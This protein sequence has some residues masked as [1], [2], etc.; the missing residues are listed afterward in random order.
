M[1][2]TAA[3]ATQT[4]A[5]EWFALCRRDA[6]TYLEHPV[7]GPVPCCVVCATIVD[8]AQNLKKIAELIG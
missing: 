7:L 2:N 4:Y 1:T 3:L 5:C 6:L 8:Q